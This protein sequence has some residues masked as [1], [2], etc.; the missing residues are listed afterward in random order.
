MFMLQHWDQ[1]VAALGSECCSTGIRVLQH[2]DQSVAA[3]GSEC[4]STGSECCSTG[5]RV[6]QHWDQ[7]VAA[8]G[9]ECCST[10]IRVLQHWDQ[11][12]AALGSEFVALESEVTAL[13]SECCSTGI[14]VLQHWDQSVAALGSECYSTGIRVLQHWDQSVAALGSECCST[15][16]RVLQHWDQ[17]VTA[18]GSECYSTGIRVRSGMN[19]LVC[20]PN[21]CGKSSLF[22]T[23]G[24][25]PYMTLG[26]LRD[27]V[28]YP[29]TPQDQ[30]AKGITDEQLEEYLKKVQLSYLLEREKGWETEQDW[31]DLLSGGEK[32]RMAMARLFYHEPQFAILDE[33]TSAVSVDVEGFIY[34]HCRERGITLFYCFSPQITMEIS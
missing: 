33:C 7:S 26:S 13:G 30:K 8:L 25:R 17:S 23:L 1:S 6:L 10:G 9:S 18:L 24:E 27:Q 20:G 14:R 15:G 31:M 5:I 2:W 28:I 34:T 22:R 3:L 32:Q 12:V 21:G 29:D 11:S 19:V 16:I 4:Y